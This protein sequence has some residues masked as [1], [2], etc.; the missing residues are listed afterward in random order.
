MLDGPSHSGRVFGIIS[1][2]ARGVQPI[3]GGQGE[4]HL[5]STSPARDGGKTRRQ[6]FG[7]NRSLDR[8]LGK[9]EVSTLS[10][11][12][13]SPPAAIAHLLFSI[14]PMPR[15]IVDM[16]S[17]SSDFLDHYALLTGSAASLSVSGA[18]CPNIQPFICRVVLS[19][20]APSGL[21]AVITSSIDRRATNESKGSSP[22]CEQPKPSRS[23]ISALGAKLTE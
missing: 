16:V 3:T 7:S 17:I 8:L 13:L 15:F 22:S 1:G 9:S 6:Q 19:S 4:T 12:G 5:P 11:R 14:T 21:P 10:M 2:I 18:S 20:G 23:D